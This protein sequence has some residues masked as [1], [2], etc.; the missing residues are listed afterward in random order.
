M[1]DQQRHAK[2]AAAQLDALSGQHQQEQERFCKEFTAG[3]ASPGN[4]PHNDT[5]TR[6]PDVH[7]VGNPTF[8]YPMWVHRESDIVS[9]EIMH[10]GVWE[11]AETV[12][13]LARLEEWKQVRLVDRSRLP[14]VACGGCRCPAV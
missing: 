8:A 3:L 5:Y 12:N 14:V 1:A 2:Q 9:N 11:H 10:N 7:A 4:T 6:V 13:I